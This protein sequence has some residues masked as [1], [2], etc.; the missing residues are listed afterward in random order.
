MA[1]NPKIMLD[2]SPD[3]LSKS[4]PIF[5]QLYTDLEINPSDT[6]VDNIFNL[7]I[8]NK[9]YED[10]RRRRQKLIEDA[11]KERLGR[12]DTTSLKKK[13]HQYTIGEI[14]FNLKDAL[15]GILNDLLKFNFTIDTFTKQNRLFYLGLF[16]LII[17]LIIYLF[18]K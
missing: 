3:K 18:K 12:L 9:K 11:E 2:N 10:V 15:F 8:F 16:I 17:I 7:D 5:N 4:D 1:S 6:Y 13:I 14:L